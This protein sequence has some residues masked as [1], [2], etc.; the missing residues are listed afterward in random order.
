M[1][2]ESQAANRKFQ[3]EITSGIASL[4]LLR[5][6]SDAPAPMYGYQISKVLGLK[7]DEA[8]LMKMG[9]IYPVLRS[10]E[11]NGLLSSE[12]EPSVSGPPRKYYTIT[13]A[14]RAILTEWTATWHE[15]QG[16][17]GNILEGNLSY[18]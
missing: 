2:D 16:Y 8:P 12:V 15:I 10:L 17:V 4:I 9:A 5:V 11:K 1:I 7:D 13:D 14:G 6:L 3:K 18:E